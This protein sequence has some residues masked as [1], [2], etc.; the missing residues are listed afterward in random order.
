[1]A[2]N[3]PYS[4]EAEREVLGAMMVS[5]DA[6]INSVIRLSE[7]DFY[8]NDHKLVFSTI[9]NVYDRGINVDV[10]TVVEQLTLNNT[11][12]TLNDKEVVYDLVEN[13]VTPSNVEEYIRI[14]Q[15]K[16]TLRELVKLADNVCNR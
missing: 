7:D 12:D 10:V 6:L 1:M 4:I 8:D 13:V 3:L 11:F 16:K 14:I 5:R 9:K 2:V 15:D